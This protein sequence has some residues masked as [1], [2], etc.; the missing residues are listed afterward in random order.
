[1]FEGDT[2]PLTNKLHKTIGR[3][4]IPRLAAASGRQAPLAQ[5]VLLERTASATQN[6]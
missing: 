6:E 1:M 3:D 5:A 4:W 2:L